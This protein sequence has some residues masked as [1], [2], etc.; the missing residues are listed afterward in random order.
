MNEKE[1]DNKETLWNRFDGSKIISLLE[2]LT[3]P[4][5]AQITDFETTR[6]ALFRQ[7]DKENFVE[8][9]VN[10]IIPT[11]KCVR[12]IDQRKVYE[13]IGKELIDLVGETRLKNYAM[14]HDKRPKEPAPLAC[15]YCDRVDYCEKNNSFECM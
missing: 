2:K 6:Q 10:G 12:E 11:E 3:K 1:I 4:G 13:D 14:F 7:L 15:K 9:S 5:G 8:I